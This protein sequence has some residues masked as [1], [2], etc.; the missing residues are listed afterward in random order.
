MAKAT[1]SID[2]SESRIIGGVVPSR[3]RFSI[4][5]LSENLSE[6]TTFG[7]EIS[8]DGDNWDVAEEAGTDVTDTLVDDTTKVVSFES[9]PGMYWQIKFAGSTTGDV[10]YIINGV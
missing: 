2:L 1:G 4:Q 6:T 7:L 8:A 9:D 3:G 10:A 5:M